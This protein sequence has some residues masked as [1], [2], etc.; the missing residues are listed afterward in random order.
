MTIDLV[1]RLEAAEEIPAAK[2][3]DVVPD[4]PGYYSIWIDDPGSLPSLFAVRLRKNQTNL[5][6]VGIATRSLHKR[7]VEQD[8]QHKSLST[9]FRGIGPVLG[10]RPL[11]GSLVG[12]KN[13]NNYKFS[14]VETEE[15]RDW[16][17][18]HLLV[19]YIE[20]ARA[21]HCVEKA[22]I[23]SSCPVLNTNHNPEAIRDLADLRKLCRDKARATA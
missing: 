1:A 4:R 14:R 12:M 21:S 8:L 19:R 7:L 13:Q 5:I 9:F 17:S 11:T 22:A 15:I 6:Y 2:A 18:N 16:I 10:Y 23:R 3:A 20:D